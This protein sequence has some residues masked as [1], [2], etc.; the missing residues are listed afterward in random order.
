VLVAHP[1]I[2]AE[3][4]RE[5]VCE[6]WAVDATDAGHAELGGTGWHWLLGDDGG[7]QW[8]ATLD[9][10]DTPEDRRTRLAAFECAAA[11]SQRLSFVVAPVHTRDD[12]VAVDLGPGLLLSVVPFLDGA[13]FGSGPFE[14]EASRADAASMMGDLHRSARSRR[15][16]VW[17]PRIGRTGAGRPELEALLRRGTGSGGPWSGPLGRLLTESAPAV[18]TA[19]RRHALLA[20]AVVGSADRWVVSHGRVDTTHLIRTLDGPRLVGW[21]GLALAPRE[22]DLRDVLGAGEGDDP[23]YAYLASGGSPEPLSPDTVELFDLELSL[24][25][26][27]E[28]GVRLAGALDDT[29]DE[30]LCFGE[31]EQELAGLQSV[32]G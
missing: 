6:D 13:P 11:L 20:A 25:R 10:V 3:L 7:P 5:V 16:P 19:L 17:R 9:V 23:W 29:A 27:A 26:V 31:L 22:R 1:D 32:W 18:A 4:V 8:F 24:S 15:L 14:T 12:R 21:S 30:R 28:D 2:S